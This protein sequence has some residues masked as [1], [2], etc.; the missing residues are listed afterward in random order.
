MT[1]QIPIFDPDADRPTRRV[2]IVAFVLATLA[3]AAI[4]SFVIRAQVHSR[5][6]GHGGIHVGNLREA[7]ANVSPP[8]GASPIRDLTARAK[9]DSALVSNRYSATGLAPGAVLDAY[10]RQLSEQG[11]VSQGRMPTGGIMME[12]FCKGEY[13]AG[14]ELHVENRYFYYAFSISWNEETVRTCAPL[15]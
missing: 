12:N 10:E 13:E 1:G 2:R 11:W 9:L 7:F 6:R 8:A 15:P 5:A 14:L 3:I 4:G